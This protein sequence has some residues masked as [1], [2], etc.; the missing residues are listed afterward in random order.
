MR[1][2]N[3]ILR[4]CKS[5]QGARKSTVEPRK[6]DIFDKLLKIRKSMRNGLKDVLSKSSIRC[7]F[8]SKIRRRN[9]FSIQVRLYDP[10]R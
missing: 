1:R 3:N 5:K 10:F 8:F 6:S 4:S 9:D 2:L 7:E